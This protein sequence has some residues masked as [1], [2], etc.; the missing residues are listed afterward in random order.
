MEQTEKPK[1]ILETDLFYEDEVMDTKPIISKYFDI[2]VVDSFSLK[3][4]D[5]IGKEFRTSLN[6]ARRMKVDLKPF[7]CTSWVPYLR[8]YMINPYHIFFNDLAYL[9]N[10]LTVSDF[11]IFARPTNG[12][13]TFSGQVFP[14][15]LRFDEEYNWMKQNNVSDD[16]MCM[17]TRYP[18][19]I[20]HE[21][22]CVVVNNKLVDMSRYMS[23]G[24]KN[25]VHEWNIQ[26]EQLCN[27]IHQ[28]L[29]FSDPNI[30]PNYPNIV[31]DIG[32][33]DG[34]FYLIEINCFETASFYGCDLDKIYSAWSQML[35]DNMES[36]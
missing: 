29:I 19:R 24:E 2:E 11:P 36:E 9:K 8:E 28:K 32:Q 6:L 17:F 14:H 12:Y 26:V 16:L 20:D 3:N 34:K 4:P 5:P 27:T 7:D 21:F 1:L 30:G 33:V 13:K 22:R 35:I 18:A 23:N 31:I 15:K 10:Y 25:V